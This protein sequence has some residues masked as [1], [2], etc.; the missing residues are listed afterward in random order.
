MGITI[1][2]YGLDGRAFDVAEAAKALYLG[3]NTFYRVIDVA[4]RVDD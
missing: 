2:G 4:V 1:T 3:P